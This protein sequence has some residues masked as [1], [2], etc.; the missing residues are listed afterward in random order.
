MREP[1][2]DFGFILQTSYSDFRFRLQTNSDSD[3]GHQLQTSDFGLR[4][5]AHSEFQI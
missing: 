3:F 2:S 5:F 4:A 1:D